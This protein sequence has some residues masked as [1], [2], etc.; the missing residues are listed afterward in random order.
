MRAHHSIESL[1][2]LA[3]G[4]VPRVAQVKPGTSLEKLRSNRDNHSF[5][6]VR[7]APPL[8]RQQLSADAAPDRHVASHEL[9][10]RPDD[11][12]EGRREWIGRR[13]GNMQRDRLHL[14]PQSQKETEVD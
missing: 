6:G 1:L 8:I 5:H 13:K 7:R 2:C 4:V 11:A 10:A 9:E 14:E 3:F 12:T